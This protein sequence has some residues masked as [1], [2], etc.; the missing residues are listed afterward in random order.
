M[1]HDLTIKT[2]AK[3]LVNR[4][5]TLN[6]LQRLN[7]RF[8]RLRDIFL[9][10]IGFTKVN[11]NDLY[12]DRPYG[13]NKLRSLNVYG[14]D[15]VID[16]SLLTKIE[17]LYLIGCSVITSM[18]PL[19]AKEVYVRNCTSIV[20]LSCFRNVKGITIDNC[21]SVTE[22]SFWDMVRHANICFCKNIISIKN[23]P[24]ICF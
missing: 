6:K 22:I 21:E 8:Y 11:K 4:N 7:I 17:R 5:A 19:N 9:S 23:L 24:K 12:M 3:Y 16:L 20:D 14:S 13:W 2:M 10:Q 15:V 1:L 18:V